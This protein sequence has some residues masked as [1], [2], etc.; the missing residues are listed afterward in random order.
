MQINSLQLE[1]IRFYEIITE[2][3]RNDTGT[4]KSKIKN[5]KKIL[6]M[7]DF[8]MKLGKEQRRRLLINA[9]WGKSIGRNT[10]NKDVN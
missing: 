6:M 5:Q 4:F 3:L 8:L 1:V 9:R 2:R 7:Q 10:E